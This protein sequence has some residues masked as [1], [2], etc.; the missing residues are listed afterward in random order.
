[1]VKRKLYHTRLYEENSRKKARFLGYSSI[2]KGDETENFICEIMSKF[3]DIED[4]QVIGSIG[5][6]FD[7][8][9]KYP[10]ECI[11]AIQVKTLVK[12][13]NTKDTWSVTFD[14]EYPS[15]TLIV[16]VNSERNRFGLITSD[17]INVTTLSLGFS[18]LNKGKYRHNKY[19]DLEIFSQSLYRRSKYSIEYNIENSIS[20]SILK[21]YYSLQ[22]LSFFCDN[23]K[24]EYK[25]NN[26]N[27]NTVDCFINNQPI[28]CK[29]SSIIQGNKCRFNLCKSNG[30]GKKQP[31]N[32]NDPIKYFIFEIGEKYHGYFCIIPKKV[33][34]TQGY[35]S[36]MN[37]EGKT[38]INI[39][40]PD[41]INHWSSEYWNKIEDLTIEDN[42]FFIKDIVDKRNNNGIIEYLVQWDGFC[43]EDST[44]E[45]E[46][47]IKDTDVYKFKFVI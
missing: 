27:C 42:M 7:I 24:L 34:I 12:N 47:N 18:K 1:M 23:N 37:N 15:G 39:C 46:E 36:D 13:H 32:I 28:Q 41:I 25:R 9:Y 29:Y 38:S 4:L 14:R 44:W 3:K 10:N 6:M 22:R 45:R 8:I 31:Y 30:V 2:T 40:T 20:E 35:I 5:G 17:N 21:E 19:I 11:R 33:L 26:T 43:N 16:L